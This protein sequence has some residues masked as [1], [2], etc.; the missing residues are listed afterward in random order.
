MLDLSINKRNIFLVVILGVLLGLVLISFLPIASTNIS[1]VLAIPLICI[2]FL[3]AIVSVKSVLVVLLFSRAL[4]DPLLNV[5]KI[6]ILGENI[7]VGG[8]I[9]FLIIILAASFIIRNPKRLSQNTLFKSWILFLSICGIAVIYSPVPGRAIKLFLDLVS[10][11]SM[12][13]VPFFVIHNLDDKK[14]WLKVL[15]FSS[16]LPVCIANF[17]L[18]RGGS[19]Y[20][21][22][23]M[24]ISGSFTHPNILAFYLVLVI[25]ISFYTL[26]NNLFKLTPVRTNLLRIYLANLFILLFATKT[27]NAWISCWVLFF[28]YGLLKERKYIFFCIFLPFLLSIFP[29]ISDR[30]NSLST[31][32]SSQLGER[33]NSFAWRLQLWKD[34]L[35]LIKN[36][37]ILGHGLASFR[38]FSYSFSSEDLLVRR[39]FASHNAYLELL[40]ETGIIG[41]ISYIMIFLT[42][43]KLL[44]SKLR[45]VAVNL[46]AGY[47]IVIT[48][49]ISYMFN[50][51]GDNLNYYLVLN[52]Y[53]WFFIGIVL[54]G[55]QFD[56][57]KKNIHNNSI[58]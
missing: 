51:F 12:A 23:G 48:Y 24:R 9:N 42:T 32:T 30:I 54:R 5:T 37:F 4:L 47:V 44:F 49:A 11:M 55:M 38:V 17:D 3:L 52:W 31:G 33:L 13:I 20:L 36:K 7:G 8:A 40:F 16:F 26:K 27:R 34:S 50:C 46:T 14:F 19:Y 57:A 18:L 43:L 56:D 1:F 41:L 45:R 2:F 53:F 35:P 10:Y 22:E 15:I 6:S 58:F 25:A 39:S 29:V 28:V 21:F